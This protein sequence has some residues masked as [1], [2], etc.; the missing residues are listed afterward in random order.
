[1]CS[2]CRTSSGSPEASDSPPGTAT[3]RAHSQHLGPGKRRPASC[4]YSLRPLAVAHPIPLCSQEP[5]FAE[6][7]PSLTDQEM[8]WLALGELQMALERA[9]GPELRISGYI[10]ARQSCD[11]EA[12]WAWRCG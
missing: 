6:V 1:M 12:R 9:G 3:S 4:C 11:G 2:P 10:T 7:L 8:D 5:G